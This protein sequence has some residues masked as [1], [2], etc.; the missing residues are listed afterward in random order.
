[1]YYNDF[2]NFYIESV[3]ID[4]PKEKMKKDITF[5]VK[6]NLSEEFIVIYLAEKMKKKGYGKSE[7]LVNSLPLGDDISS[8]MVEVHKNNHGAML[9]VLMENNGDSIAL[10]FDSYTTK[11][12]DEVTKCMLK[13]FMLSVEQ[14][15]KS[16]MKKDEKLI[17][18]WE[19]DKE[20][21]FKKVPLEDF[22][23]KKEKT[24][25]P[26]EIETDSGKEKNSR[27]RT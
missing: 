22:L 11:E 26:I 15:A 14:F 6:G 17:V 5:G 12:N 20:H 23:D 24:V 16:Y 4:I 2:V 13:D 10:Q 1:M 7:V 27:G 18:D 21:K 19:Y 9:G 25:K 8:A 3:F